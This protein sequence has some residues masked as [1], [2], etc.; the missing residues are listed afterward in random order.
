MK[1]P[2]GAISNFVVFDDAAAAAAVVM[3]YGDDPQAL[4][5]ILTTSYIV[6]TNKAHIRFVILGLG[7]L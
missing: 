4:C 6:D 2:M 1:L 3:V 7:K 5:F